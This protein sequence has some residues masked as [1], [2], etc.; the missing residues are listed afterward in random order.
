MDYEELKVI[1]HI[2][3]ISVRGVRCQADIVAAARK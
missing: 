3:I 2:N 1:Y